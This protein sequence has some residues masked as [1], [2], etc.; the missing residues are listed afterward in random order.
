MQVDCTFPVFGDSCPMEHYYLLQGG[1]SRL[2]PAFHGPAGEFRFAAITGDLGE[3]GLLRIT[4]KSRLRVR[5]PAER[6]VSV[7]PLAGQSVLVGKHTIRLGNPTVQALTPAPLLAAKIVTFKNAEEPARF[8]AHAGERLRELG[9]QGEPAIPLT[10]KGRH[11]GEP[12]REIIRI[13]GHCI[14]GYAL[15]VSGLSADESIRL[16]ESGLGGRTRM[17]CG[18]FLPYRPRES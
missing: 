1:L 11:A 18:F 3:R 7:L 6:I 17:G 4:G 14:I 8:L 9:I 10:E 16:Q 12:R 15:Q 13:K 5:V 2:V